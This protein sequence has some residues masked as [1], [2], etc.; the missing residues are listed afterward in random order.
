MHFFDC[1]GKC[2]GPG[3]TGLGVGPIG[4][5]RRSKSLDGPPEGAH[6]TSQS[7]PERHKCQ[8]NPFPVV[9]QCGT[10][11]VIMDFGTLVI[12]LIIIN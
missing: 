2:E 10:P 1:G 5:N 8:Q 12:L 4:L 9:T 11:F 6:G 7:S 3:L